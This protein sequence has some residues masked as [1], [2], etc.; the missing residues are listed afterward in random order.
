MQQAERYNPD[1]N[2]GLT[3]TQIEE[4]KKAGLVNYDTTVKSKSFKSI[5]IEN[6]FTIFNLLNLILALAV[7]FTG[8]YKNMTFM[9][10]VFFNTAISIFQEIRSKIA[11]DKLAVIS[12][13]KVNAVRRGKEEQIGINELVLDD[14]IRLSA[15]NQIITDSIICS[16]RSRG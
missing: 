7:Y 15:G 13:T 5:I 16:R 12:A 11:V 3:E 1:L 6:I 8:S 10:I 14:I 9:I 4:R 2:F